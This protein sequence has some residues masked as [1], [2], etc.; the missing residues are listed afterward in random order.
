MAIRL[1]NR[2]ECPPGGFI[3]TISKLSTSRQ[4]WSFSDALAWFDGVARANPQAGLPTNP[5]VQADFIDQQNALRCLTFQGGDSYISEKGG[6]TAHAETKKASLLKPVVAVADKVRQLKAGVKVLSDWIGA[7]AHPVEQAEAD[8]R[9]AICEKCPQNGHGDW[10]SWFT[11]PAAAEIR[12]LLESAKQADL[13]TAL[14]DKLGVCEAC[15][16]PLKLKV[17][18]PLDHIKTHISAT[19]K[20]SLDKRCWILE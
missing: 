19:A 10:T 18:V 15:L 7:G 6:P 1:K 4:F 8:R 12:T 5:T 3:V 11:L 2:S 14:D 9:A 16:C 17:H 20:A 13:K